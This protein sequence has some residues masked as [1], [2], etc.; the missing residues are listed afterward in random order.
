MR[1]IGLGIVGLTK[2]SVDVGPG[3]WVLW[4]REEFGCGPLLDKFPKVKED[5][6][7]SEAPGLAQAMCNEDNR[8]FPLQHLKE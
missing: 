6:V 3:P 5:H 2:H 8:I 4:F 7:V 1:L